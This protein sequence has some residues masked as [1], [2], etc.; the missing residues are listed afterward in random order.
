MDWEIRG[1]FGSDVGIMA[2]RIFIEIT[3]DFFNVLQVV[4]L[5]TLTEQVCISKV[6]DIVI[7]VDPARGHC[8]QGLTKPCESRGQRPRHT[9]Q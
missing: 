8:Y 1:I 6:K 5:I 7:L 3:V 9:A 2:I 4:L